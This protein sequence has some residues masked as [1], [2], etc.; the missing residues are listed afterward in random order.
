MF[1][2]PEAHESR[3]LAPSW[4]RKINKQ[5]TITGPAALRDKQLSAAAVWAKAFGITKAIA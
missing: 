5:L 3:V 4:L 2:A 1:R